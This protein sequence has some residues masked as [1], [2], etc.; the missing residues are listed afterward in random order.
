[1]IS[2]ENL[3]FRSI[4]LLSIA[5]VALL[6][7][8]SLYV[9]TRI[10]VSSGQG[11]PDEFLMLFAIPILIA[12]IVGSLPVFAR[13]EPRRLHIAQSRKALTSVWAVLLLFFLVIH[14]ILLLDVL[15]R[16]TPITTYWPV[17]AGLVC[18]VMGNYLGK[19]QSNHIAGFRTPWT[20]SSELSWNKTHRFGGKLLVLLG[21]ILIAGSVMIVGDF[22][23]YFL[24]VSSLLW[25]V[26][27][28]IYS[29][30]IWKRDPDGA[31]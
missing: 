13:I 29:Y 14:I 28:F 7:A 22:W 5:E 15:G 1:M 27:L 17:L 30:V 3:G 19:I 6:F 4:Y 21:V 11:E 16:E 31:K 10:P 12:V 25:T 26:V 2:R 18:M 24:L 23:V 8:L 20:L 9:W